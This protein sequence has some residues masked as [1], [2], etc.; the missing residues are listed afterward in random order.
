MLAE[1]LPGLLPP[2][3]VEDALDV[4]AIHS[5][6]GRL[7][8]SAPLMTRPPFQDPH[9]TATTA[10]VVGGGSGI[11]K[12]GA[13]SL[14]HRGILFLDEAPEFAARVIDALRQPLERGVV[15]VAR[16]GG[17]ATYPA[18]FTLVLAANP[19]PCG[20][21]EDRCSC[22]SAVRRRYL[23]RLSGPV[24]DRVDLR[25]R[26]PRTTRAE[27]LAD[28]GFGEPSSV[29]A[30]RVAAAR[31][32]AA[33]RYRGTPWRLNA[34]VPPTELRRRWPLPRKATR[35]A[36]QALDVGQLTARG[37]GRVLSVA[38]TLADLQGVGAPRAEQVGH[39]LGMR[40]GP[41]AAVAA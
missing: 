24:L 30:A 3:C 5:V 40:T 26:V 41:A 10:A 1:R 39:A 19:C 16:V 12:P 31:A 17:T 6:A 29:V 27:M 37:F 38:W 34:D 4:T 14:A 22:P 32:A 11:A 8:S 36:E 18:R 35:S 20:Q 23:A 33:E 25:V 9:H 21:D 28:D 15:K 2:L 7:P 13:A